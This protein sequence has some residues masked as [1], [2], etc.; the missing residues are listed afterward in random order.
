MIL[1]NEAE[2]RTRLEGQGF[3][4]VDVASSTAQ[5]LIAACRGA[6]VVVSVEG[7]HLAPL[8]YLMSDW[9]AM[10]ILNPP[11]QVQTTVAT[12]ALFCS[13]TSGMFICEPCGDSRTD[14]IADA[15]ELMRFVD[16]AID[17]AIRTQARHR[18]VPRSHVA[19]RRTAEPVRRGARRRRP[20]PA[21]GI[22]TPPARM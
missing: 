2:V 8:L 9:S 13:I 11:Y 18:A 7:S 20:R 4:T 5:Q 19:A 10:M 15:D 22:V 14:F 16:A 17:F 1:V 21:I 3:V 6:R 12:V